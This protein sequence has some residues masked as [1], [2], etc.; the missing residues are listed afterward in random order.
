MSGANKIPGILGGILQDPPPEFAFEIGADGIAVSR[1]RPP[2]TVQQAALRPGVLNPSPVKENILDPVAFVEAVRK[3]VPPAAAGGRRTAAL[4][5]PD[6]CVRIAVL[7]FDTLP[8]KE[9]DRRALINFRLRKSVPFDVDGAAL[10]Y[11]QPSANNVVVALAPAEIVAHYE[12]PFRAA[13]LTPGLVTVSSLAMLEILP[14]TGSFLLAR[15]SPGTLTVLA[16][17]DGAVTIARSLELTP[18]T[19]DPLDEISTDIY[20]TIA[21]IEDQTGARPQ[22]LFLAGFGDEGITSATRLAIELDLEVEALPQVNPGLAGYLAGLNSAVNLATEP[23]R[24]DRPMLVGSAVAATLL[25]ATLVLLIVLASSDRR[26]I[27]ENS[28]ALNRVNG[29]LAGVAREQ[30]KIDAT[31]RLAGNEVVLDRSVLINALIK[32]KAISWT[33]IFGDLEKVL[34]ANVRLVAVRPQ[35]NAL[36][37]LSLDMTIAAEAP[38]QVIHFIAELE[39]SDVFGS[40]AVSG[41]T[42]PTQTDPFYRYRLTV[43]YAQKL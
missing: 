16:V 26:Q 34:P 5:L 15:R 40:T 41:I 31:M 20:P 32:R 42:P 2:A 14:K 11:F 36:D 10:A 38:E 1:T 22:K 33:R 21:Y 18:D 24:R 17:K 4:I 28:T 19:I 23:F 27:R 8:E 39:G 9:D 37:Q 30:T 3:L 29:E 35:V 12:A 6:N 7:E 43:N 13:G 25:V